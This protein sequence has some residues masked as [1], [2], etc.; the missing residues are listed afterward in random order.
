VKKS[1]AAGVEKLSKQVV[2]KIMGKK[3][4]SFEKNI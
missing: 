1:C 4:K 3:G 2:N